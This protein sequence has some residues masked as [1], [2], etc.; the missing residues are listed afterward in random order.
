MMSV[1]GCSSAGR[2]RIAFGTHDDD[3]INLVKQRVKDVMKL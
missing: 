2:S 1:G 3:S